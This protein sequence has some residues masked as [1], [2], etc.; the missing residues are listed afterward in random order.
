[1]LIYRGYKYQCQLSGVNYS[2]QLILAFNYLW[3]QRY[4]AN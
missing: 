4:S 1:M 2:G 3:Q